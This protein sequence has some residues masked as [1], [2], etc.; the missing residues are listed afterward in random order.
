MAQSQVN[1]VQNEARRKTRTVIN[2]KIG[3]IGEKG[4][5]KKGISI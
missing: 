1:R 5:D 4:K 2:D 3:K